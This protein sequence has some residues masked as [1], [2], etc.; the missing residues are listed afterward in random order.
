VDDIK[1]RLG[2]FSDAPS[3]WEMLQGAPLALEDAEVGVGL[4]RSAGLVLKG[5][6]GTSRSGKMGASDASQS[7]RQSCPSSPS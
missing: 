2:H 5:F 1:E 3:W 4:G 7:Q 6:S